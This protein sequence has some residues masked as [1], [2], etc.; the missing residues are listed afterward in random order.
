MTAEETVHARGRKARTPLLLQARGDLGQR[1]VG[2]RLD[3]RQNRRA[4]G[5]D[6]VGPPVPALPARCQRTGLPPQPPPL[7]RRRRCHTKSRRRRAATRSGLNHRNPT[8]TKVQR[9]GLGHEGW[10]SSPAS[11]VNHT[12]TNLGI[13]PDSIRSRNALA[14]I[15]AALTACVVVALPRRTCPIMLPS[16]PSKG[17]HHQTLGS[18]WVKSRRVSG[19]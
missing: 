14:L 12:P 2:G 10:P 13:R 1:D 5:L 4:A 17:S 8:L 6:P 7:D 16:M 18:N 3:Q 11:T 9:Q 15:I 19:S